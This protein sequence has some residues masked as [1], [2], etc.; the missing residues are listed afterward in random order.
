MRFGRKP[1]LQEEERNERGQVG[2]KAHGFLILPV[3]FWYA[4]VS[5]RKSARVLAE[6][7]ASFA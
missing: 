6:F 2:E 4:S 3:L 5:K 1:S 7:T